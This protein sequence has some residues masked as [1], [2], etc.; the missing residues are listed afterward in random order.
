MLQER[1]EFPTLDEQ[2]IARSIVVGHIRSGRY[3][4]KSKD[5]SSIQPDGS[6]V[7]CL[8]PPPMYLWFDVD[9]V[10][11]G[12]QVARHIEIF[13]TSH[14]GFGQLAAHVPLVLRTR[15]GGRLVSS[16]DDLWYPDDLRWRSSRVS[17]ISVGRR[18]EHR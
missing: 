10:L 13:T 15:G 14:Y 9:E 5:C 6:M 8:G 11:A 16:G 18:A 1:F 17:I 2:N 7:V 12:A 4:P 3:L